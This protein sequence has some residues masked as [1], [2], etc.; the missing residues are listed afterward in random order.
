[1][2]YYPKYE[3]IEISYHLS[4]GSIAKDTLRSPCLLAKLVTSSSFMSNARNSPSVPEVRFKGIATFFL[5]VEL[6]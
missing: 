6:T 4:S 3:Y 2:G 1:M 5:I